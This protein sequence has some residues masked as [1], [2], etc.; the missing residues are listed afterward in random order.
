MEQK[1]KTANPWKRATFILIGLIVFWFILNFI[2]INDEIKESTSLETLCEVTESYPGW[3]NWRGESIGNGLIFVEND[4]VEKIISERIYF[5]YDSEC[6]VCQIQIGL[7]GEE[8][9]R[10]V[11]SGFTRNCSKLN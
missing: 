10:Y 6:V 11:K 3:F 7:F 1:N 5:V 2:L 9:E 8:W 4:T